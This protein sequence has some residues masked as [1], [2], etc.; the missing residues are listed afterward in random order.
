MAIRP[1][2]FLGKYKTLKLSCGRKECVTSRP[3]FVPRLGKFLINIFRVSQPTKSDGFCKT[4]PRNGT[5]RIG[6]F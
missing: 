3:S 6:N 1:R 5:E 4:A 2:T